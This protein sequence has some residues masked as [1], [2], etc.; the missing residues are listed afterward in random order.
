[1][2]AHW[3]LDT[4]TFAN[5]ESLSTFQKDLPLEWIEEVLEKLTK[6]AFENVN[7]L[8]SYFG[9]TRLCVE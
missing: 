6:R 4:D 1:L 8:L 9:S 3:L 5:P 2:L 7:C